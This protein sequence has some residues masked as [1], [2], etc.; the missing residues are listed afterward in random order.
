MTKRTVGRSGRAEPEVGWFRRPPRRA[1]AA[2]L[3]VAVFVTACTPERGAP[4]GEGTEWVVPAHPITVEGGRFVDTRSGREFPVRGVNYFHIVEAGTGLQDRFFSP[5]VFDAQVVRRD[6]AA[7]AERGYTTV[8]I[9]LDSCS[10]GTA[11]IT[12]AGETGINGEFLDVIAETTQIARQ[13]G[14]FLLLTSND[15]PEGGGYTAIADAANSE[16]FPGY[17]NTH[18]LTA[19]GASAAASYWDDLLSALVQRQAAFDAVLGWSILNE[20]WVFADQPPLSLGAGLVTGADGRSYDVANPDQKRALVTAGVTHYIETV[21]EVIRGHD[22]TGLVTMG[23]FAPQFPNLTSIGGSWYVDTTPLLTTSM[24]FFDFHAYPGSDIGM[25]EIAE[26]FGMVG[27]GTKPVIMGEVG[28][29]VDRYPTSEAAALATQRWIAES[30]AAGYS[31]WLYWGFLRAPEAIGDATWALTDDGGYLLDVL[32]PQNWPDPCVVSIVDPNLARERPVRTSRELADEPASAAVDG[33]PAT[34]WGSGSDAPQWIEVTLPQPSTVAG[35]RLRV[36]QYPAGRTV[37]EV[38]VSIEGGSLTTVH[39]FD[40][41]TEDGQV[42]E[43]SFDRAIT[44]VTAVRVTTTVSP[45][46][47]SW[48]EVEVLATP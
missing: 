18:F 38:A 14:V 36:A 5:E 26:N 39:V 20:Q 28:A 34:Q 21:A 19:A 15:L 46:W 29:F 6:F 12:R 41:V 35:I 4:D 33:N 40:G 27:F 44:G 3:A 23:F 25:A 11:C 42:I 13:T 47:V 2:L 45:S 22:P 24:D 7:L 31:G 17:R 8:R 43:A 1:L 32:A 48:A 30:C 9:F 10:I 37:H 16:H